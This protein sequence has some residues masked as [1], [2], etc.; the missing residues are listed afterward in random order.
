MI[1]SQ[2]S[3]DDPL[4]GVLTALGAQSTGVTRLQARG[5]WALSF[6]EKHRLKLVAVIRGQA[7][8]RLPRRAAERV[9]EG[10]VLLIGS[11]P[12]VIASDPHATPV[13]GVSPYA[14]QDSVCLGER[15][16]AKDGEEAVFIGAGI[17]FGDEDGRF[18]LDALPRFMAIHSAS[19]SAV[20]VRRIL[21]LLDAETGRQ[22]MGSARVAACLSEVLVVEALR[23]YM[24]TQASAPTGW[25]GALGDHHIGAALTL[26]HRDVSHAWT[27]AELASRV[28]MSRSA[29]SSRFSETVGQAP[30]QYLTQWRMLLA[31]RLLAESD[32]ELVRV[33]EQVGYRSASAF[34]HAFKRMFGEAPKRLV[35][36]R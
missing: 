12:Y 36:P 31:R 4:S 15:D 5:E 18:L 26:M 32:M 33:A 13:D 7:W 14:G 20:A 6:P 30:L 16:G 34:G 29:F 2:S 24:Q 27:V 23:A 17:V 1:P 8:I 3:N 25:I 9:V 22:R 19:P 10:Q 35:R 11:T 21:E 28:G